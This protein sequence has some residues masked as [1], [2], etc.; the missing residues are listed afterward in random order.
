MN[1]M[2]VKLFDG[3]TVKHLFLDMCTTK[4][5]SSGRAETIFNKMDDVFS[6]LDIPWSNCVALSVDNASVNLGIRN[7]LKSRISQKNDSIYF[8]GCPCHIIHNTASK[9]SDAFAEVI[10]N[11]IFCLGSHKYYCC[12]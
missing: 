3:N 7:S 4:G 5:T 9:A 2:T 1:P 6:R 12:F 10:M 8:L 11:C